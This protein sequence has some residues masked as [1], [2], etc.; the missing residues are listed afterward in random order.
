[1]LARSDPTDRTVNT[2]PSCNRPAR[3]TSHPTK[4]FI[5]RGKVNRI[6]ETPVMV[7]QNLVNS[8]S[9]EVCLCLLQVFQMIP[10]LG[11]GCYN[12][13][14]PTAPGK[15]FRNVPCTHGGNSLNRWEIPCQEKELGTAALLFCLRV[16]G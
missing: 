6:Q 9:F 10:Q 15:V 2:Q 11:R 1:M 13:Y 16:I 8:L 7:S 12:G 14:V 3:S 4:P 5:P